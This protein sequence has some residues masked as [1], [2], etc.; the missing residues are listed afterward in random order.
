MGVSVCSRAI[1][2]PE[3]QW[4]SAIPDIVLLGAE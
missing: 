4:V 3:T 1:L 2:I